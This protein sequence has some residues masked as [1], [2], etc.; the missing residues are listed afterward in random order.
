MYSAQKIIPKLQ[1]KIKV[2]LHKDQYG[3][4]VLWHQL[5]QQHARE[6]AEFS[7]AN[8]FSCYWNL[9]LLLFEYVNAF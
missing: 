9:K 1:N 2:K 3:V 4:D 7:E 5:E 6:T 8:G